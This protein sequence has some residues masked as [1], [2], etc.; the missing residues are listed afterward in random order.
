VKGEKFKDK[1]SHFKSYWYAFSMSVTT[2]LLPKPLTQLGPHDPAFQ[3]TELQHLKRLADAG[4]TVAPILV[5]PASLEEYFYR[6]NN[7][8]A[9][10]TTIFAKINLKNPDEDE[11]E[12]AVPQA[13]ALFKRHYLL[14][15]VIDIFYEQLEFLPERVTVRRAGETGKTILKGRPA[16]MALK[17]V[18]MDDWSFETVLERVER[19]KTIG[20]EARPTLISA[21]STGQAN[22]SLLNQ[23]KNVLG[24]EVEAEVSEAVGITRIAKAEG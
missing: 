10:L 21:E 16:L 17:E 1:S 3:Q 20:L 18:W 12:D 7:L 8:P 22:P 11:V 15:E 23:V 4:L 24:Q 5:V 2:N 14:D 19:T 9:Q 6:L 13:Q